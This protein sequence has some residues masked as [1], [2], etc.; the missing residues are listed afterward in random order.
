[1]TLDAGGRS[2]R[3]AEALGIPAHHRST[4]SPRRHR[5]P[6]QSNRN[7]LTHAGFGWEFFSLP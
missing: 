7:I 4:S 5:L 1:M 6:D 2:L 3:D